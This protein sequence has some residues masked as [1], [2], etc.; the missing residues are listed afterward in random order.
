MGNFRKGSQHRL[1]L[2]LVLAA[3]ALVAAIAVTGCGGGD[4]AS[5]SGDGSD[6]GDGQIDLVAYSTPQEAYENV[7]QPAFQETPEGDGVSFTNSFAASG[8]SRRAVE[9]G[10][11][12]DYV[13]FALETDMTPLV[14]AGIVAETWR[15]NKYK[16]IVTN[17][18]VAIVT[19]PGNPEKVKSFQDIVDKKLDVVTANPAVSGG[20]RWNILAVWGSITT[21]GGSEDEAREFTKQILSQATV[22]PTSARDALQAFLGGEG[23]VLL[24]YENEAIAALNAD[25]EIDYVVPDDTLLI[26]QPGAVTVDAGPDATAFLDWLWTDAAQ[27]LWAEAGYRPV[28][29]ALVDESRFPTPKNLYTIDDDFGGCDALI[30]DLGLCERRQGGEADRG[31]QQG[32]FQD[33][34]S[35]S[36]AS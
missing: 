15:D 7:L 30:G 18:V 17:S 27:N 24:S 14:D 11:P 20:A 32:R 36:V 29:P 23:D 10:Q 16:G 28:N 1:G 25:Q 33:V 35:H 12:A 3:C 19:R 34:K 6:G 31:A 8:D 13:N 9:A 26:E 22:Q 5:G 21:N 4:S 2:R